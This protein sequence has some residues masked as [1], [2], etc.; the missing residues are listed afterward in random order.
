[1]AAFDPSRLYVSLLNT[2]LQTRDNALYQVIHDL[3]GTLAGVNKQVNVIGTPSAPA[4]TTIQQ[5]IGIPG[6]DGESIEGLP[7][8][9]GKDGIQGIQGIQ[10]MPG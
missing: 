10:G 3:I 9:Q 5:L 8:L 7:G 2:G 4:T 1:M 6:E